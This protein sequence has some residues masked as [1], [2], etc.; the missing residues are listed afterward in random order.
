M[1]LSCSVAIS[2]MLPLGLFAQTFTIRGKVLDDQ[3]QPFVGATVSLQHPWGEVVKNTATN[4]EGVFILTQIERGGYRLVISALGFKPLRR[5]VTLSQGDVHLG[6][7]QLEADQVVLQGVEI[8]STVPIAQQK[9]DTT[10]FNASSVKVM[11]DAD[12]ADLVE[13][14]PS[15]SIES[16]TIKAQGE[17][18]AQVLVDGKPFFGNDP[19]AALRNLPAEVIDK[20]QIFDQQSE[21]A[22]FTGFQD[23]NTTKTINIVTKSNMRQG[24]FG[25][26]Y[27]GY[28]Y[29]ERYQ[30]GGNINIFDGDRRIALIGMANN[31]NIQNFSMDD[32]L[33]V[34][35]SNSGRGMP[36]GGRMFMMMGG[37]RGGPGGGPGGPSG[38]LGDFLVR[39]QGG[40]A[41]TSAV[42]INYSDKWGQK[43]DV[44]ASYFFNNSNA[45]AI[46]N[47]FRQFVN[48]LEDR[49][50][51][52]REYG[53]SR[54]DNT[55]HRFNARIEYKLDSMNSF[56]FRPRFTAQVNDG[57]SAAT[58]QTLFN[59][60]LI[61]RTDNEYR[62]DLTALNINSE[63]LWR[64]RM[65]KKGRTFSLSLTGGYAPKRGT[66][67]LESENRF[68]QQNVTSMLNQNT[69]LDIGNWNAAANAEYTEPLSENAQVLL[70][71]RYSYQQEAS[72]RFTYDWNEQTGSYALLN[73]QLSNV[74][75]NDY[76]T[77]QTGA[78]YSYS[79]EREFNFNVR[80]NAQWATLANRRTFPQ[81]ANINQAFFNVLPSA[82]LRYDL[83]RT[84]NVRI[85]YRSNTQLP[86][87]EQLQDVVNN[88]NPV[89]L[90]VG[91]PNLRQTFQ[92]NIFGR[93]QASN[94]EKGNTIFFGGGFTFTQDYIA[95]ATYLANSDHPILREYQV[96]RGARLSRP[97]NLDGFY[98]VRVFGSYG[99]PIK[100]LKTNVN[101][102]A[103]YNY[104]RTPGLINDVLNIASNHILTV[105]LTFAS[106]I[107]DRIDFS[108]ALRPSYNVAN[109]TFQTASNTRYVSQTSRF[110]FNWI[111]WKGIVLRSDLTHNL[112]A[113]LSEG[114]N[115]NFW[116]WHLAL[117]K[118]VFKNERGEIALAINDVL[119][120]NR[121]I[122][123]NV[124]ETYVE[125]LQ[126]NALQRFVMLSFTYNLR[127]FRT[128]REPSVVREGP[129]LWE[130]GVLRM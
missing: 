52:Y 128:K 96:P 18:V 21:Q 14:L 51:L 62:S 58:G 64:R 70:N 130:P 33:G 76:V 98:S 79:K 75:S 90:T 38:G 10:E 48:S 15:V 17:N 29:E 25:K 113:G 9:G 118:K 11:K 54:T 122:G 89:Q 114:F 55:N 24:Q 92:Q 66:A 46:N 4:Q 12:A 97:V 42:G 68:P 63:L 81:E 124:T 47:I 34:M 111:V 26:L 5:E 45:L 119:G 19:M 110:R 102:D 40:I 8:K 83:D 93:Y 69:S 16:G 39:P 127:H 49:A 27:A 7:L 67:Q 85:F 125:D 100:G 3:G 115:Q 73:E 84:R 35:G 72:D 82:M 77:H 91:N 116:L 59:N 65:A 28:G 37:G 123:R 88:S 109:N 31:I 50:E 43:A 95:T 80:I 71:Y 103:F 104:I 36:G 13:K 101:L 106:N 23:G 107:S 20:I 41:T 30:A 87:V 44:T 129:S 61:G 120:Q 57:T 78:G 105:G 99:A 108:L 121:S 6:V 126:T 1:K 94:P 60:A 53:E 56:V 86:S 2:L 22:Q 32:L 112:N 74:F 117:G